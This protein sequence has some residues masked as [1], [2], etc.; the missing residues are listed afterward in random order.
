MTLETDATTIPAKTVQIF[1]QLKELRRVT[2]QLREEAG[3]ISSAATE[4]L[5]DSLDGDIWGAE[6]L[7]VQLET[8]LSA[9]EKGKGIFLLVETAALVNLGQGTA[10]VTRIGGGLSVPCDNVYLG[11]ILRTGIGSSITDGRSI[12]GELFIQQAG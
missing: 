1:G 12:E 4:N 9:F 7:L 11:A 10:N 2:A 3:N 8:K 6:R 5:C